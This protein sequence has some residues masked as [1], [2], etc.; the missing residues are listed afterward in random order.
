MKRWLKRIALGFVALIILAALGLGGYVWSFARSVPSYSG[1]AQVTG[2]KAPVNILRDRYAIPHIRAQSFEDAAFGLGYAHAQDRLWQMEMARRF[3]QGRLSEMFGASA[4]AADA[5]MR[6]MGLYEAAQDAVPHLSEDAR[7]V[8]EAYAAG[9]NAY[10]HEGR[11]LPIEFALAGVKPE[12]WMPADSVAVLK[13][14]A[15]QL[16]G[17]MYGEVA[18]AQ[19]VPVLGRKGV[20]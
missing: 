10:L 15:F 18:R 13:G 20:Q 2:L 8:L 17:N 19:L 4:L 14:M 1:G 6:A 9:V 12:P 3:V 5:S 16:S 11:P 7:R